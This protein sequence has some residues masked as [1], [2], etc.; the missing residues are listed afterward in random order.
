MQFRRSVDAA[1]A[2]KVDAGGDDNARSQLSATNFS[3]RASVYRLALHLTWALALDWP[4][5]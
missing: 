4:A 2:R 3:R 5:G 1:S